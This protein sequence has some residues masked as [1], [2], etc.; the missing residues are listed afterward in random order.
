MNTDNE[1]LSAEI[2][3]ELIRILDYWETY[4]LDYENGGFYGTVNYDNIPDKKSERSVV[5]TSRILWTF[6]MAYRLLKNKK[7]LAIAERAEHYLFNH[8]RD[9]KYGGVYW[10]VTAKGES[11][12]TKKQLYGH[13]FAIY[14]LS[15]YYA[16]TKS[17]PALDFAKAIFER[18]DKEGF[19]PEKGGYFECF[20][21]DWSQTDDF[22]LSKPPYNK[23]MNTHLHLLEAFTNLYRV[24]PDPKLKSRTENVLSMMLDNIIDPDTHR[25]RLLFDKNWQPKDYTISYGHDIEA[26]WLICEAAEVLGNEELIKRVG[27]RSIKMAEATLD[28]LAKDGILNYEFD[29]VTKHLNT[30][31]S[32]WVV[33]EQMVGFMNAY[34]LSK[35]EHF[36][37][38]TLATW[39]FIKKYQRDM[40]N[41]DWH[42]T[43][44][45]D[46]TIPKTSKVNP[47]KGPYHHSRACFE[48]I[49]RLEAV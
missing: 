6:S 46:L 45:A 31:R 37:Q 44:K 32:W 30:D 38:K 9:E 43:V 15:E 21:R 26:S 25:Q 14:G 13:S 40:V 35:Q 23:S 29:P 1:K 47:W 24:W 10:S 42:A 18:I 17:K 7:Y 11:L 41:G 33:A 16:A 3:K 49:K 27:G 28:G 39:E 20:A 36:W 2:Q 22:I 5:V 34:Q 8:F 48:M 12:E 4:T 19:D